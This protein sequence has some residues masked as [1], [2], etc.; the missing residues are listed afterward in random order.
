MFTIYLCFENEEKITVKILKVEEKDT[1]ATPR[2]S[3]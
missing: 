1:T 3:F 2:Q